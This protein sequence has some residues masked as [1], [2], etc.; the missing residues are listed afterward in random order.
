[1][2]FDPE[3]ASAQKLKEHFRVSENNA[4]NDMSNKMFESLHERLKLR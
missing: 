3:S 1:M 4:L 2:D